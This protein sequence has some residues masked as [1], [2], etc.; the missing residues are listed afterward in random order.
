MAE[1]EQRQQFVEIEYCMGKYFLQYFAPIVDREYKILKDKQAEEFRRRLDGR[2]VAPG[3]SGMM[4]ASMAAKEVCMTG[5]WNT[6]NADYLLEHCNGK[7]FSDKNVKEDINKMRIAMRSVLVSKLGVDKYKEL[8]RGLPGGDLASYYVANRFQ[9][10]F[11]E[12]LAKKEMPKGTVDYIFKKGLQDS[13][14][15]LLGGIG[16]SDSDLDETVK[17]LSERFY[18]PSGASKAAAFGLSFLADTAMTGGYGSVAKTG[19]WL[20]G[21]AALRVGSDFISDD[22][23]F[24][25]ALSKQLWDDEKA[26]DDIRDTSRTVQTQKSK[27]VLVF[28][29]L[30]K[31]Q[32]FTPRFDGREYLEFAKLLRSKFALS[33]GDA[34]AAH[35]PS[36]LNKL[37]ITVSSKTAVPSWMNEKSDKELYSFATSWTARALELGEKGIKTQKIG[38]KVYTIEEM[39]QK[40]YDYARALSL[41]QQSKERSEVRKPEV[42]APGDVVLDEEVAA[43]SQALVSHRQVSGI[44]MQAASL[45]QPS[46]DVPMQNVSG[47]GGFLDGMGLGGFSDIG[48]N[49]GYVLAMLPD[50]LI[51]M[52]TG[53]TRNLKFKDN[54]LPIAS[55]V[56]GM[57]VRNPLL[58]LL[59]IGFGGA[60]LLNKAG[61]EALENGGVVSRP[62][63]VRQYRTYDDEPLSLRIKD[64]MMKGNTLLASIDHVPC[65]I[66]INEEVVDAYEN[67]TLPLNTLANAVLSRYDEQKRV[68]QENYD[69]ELSSGIRHRVSHSEDEERNMVLR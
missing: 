65:V 7:F 52:F 42:L 58:K 48:K 24:D 55:I 8:G 17:V 34:L 67:K 4:N 40:G 49:L 19:A 6:K 21:D 35:L 53:K 56:A 22:R 1:L 43:R 57:F 26:I 31:N 51:G 66:T 68:L 39:A 14:P 36:Y 12:R 69:R 33:Q 20:V 44:G 18:N 45:E 62:S 25:Q 63:P 59:L 16:L 5:E 10:L 29:S 3:M 2:P 37:G 64:P 60:N 9:T 41:R 13:L 15:G 11:V 38:G 32:I 30:L 27:D 50:M 61:H 46:Q 28:N 23:T 54:M 47:W